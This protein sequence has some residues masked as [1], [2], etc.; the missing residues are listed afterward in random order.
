MCAVLQE[1]VIR[2]FVGSPGDVAAE[3]ESVFQVI[4][5]INDDPFRPTGYRLRAVAWDKTHYPKI[6]WLSPQEAINRGLPGPGHCEISVFIFWS[7]VGTPLA[8]GTFRPNGS[9]DQPTGSLWEFHEAM[10]MLES[11]DAEPGSVLHV[12]QKGYTLNGRLVRAAKVMVAKAPAADE[13]PAVDE[14]Q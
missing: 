6:A 1:Q 9:G 2:V 13:A 12:L 5:D 10:S 8:P 4:A 11:A 3:R 14:E 7:R